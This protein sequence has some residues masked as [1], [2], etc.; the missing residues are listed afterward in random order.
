M[1]SQSPQR[2]RLR[3]PFLAAGIILIGANLRSPVTSLGPVLPDIQAALGLNGAAAGLLNALPLLLFALLSLIAPAVGRWHGLERVLGGSIFAIAVGIAI[4]SLPLPGAIWMGTV[5]LSAGIAFGNVL[6]PG[7]IKRDFPK[8]AGGLIG[9]Y[10]AAMATMAGIAAGVAVP[11]AHIGGANWRWSLGIW[12]LPAIITLLVWMPQFRV[13]QHHP[14]PASRS[15]QTSASPWHHSVGW[16][17]SLFFAFHSM[18][19]YSLVD[20]FA[21]YA[22]EHDISVAWAGVLLL[23]YQVV[24]VST[25]LGSASLIRRFTNQVALGVACGLLLL[26][27]TVGLLLAPNF[28]LIWLSL[29]GLGAGIAMVTSLSLFGLRTRDHH[30]AMALSGMAQFVG[31]TGAAF[32]PFLFGVLRDATGGWT[33]SLM[34]LVAASCLVI[35]FAGLAGRTQTIG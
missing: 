11:I 29:A 9:L 28:A 3:A 31:Y 22:A 24:A 25:N 35:V 18:V 2:E 4:R 10:A 19:F 14:R 12:A 16:Q 21:S 20:W 7:L 6:L 23:L 26:A 5:L 33:A 8:S 32:G 13:P 34:L 30:S 17:V 1:L 15:D 27:G